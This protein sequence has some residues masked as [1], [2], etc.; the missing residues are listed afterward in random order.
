MPLILLP[1]SKKLLNLSN[2][3]TIEFE[4]ERDSD[5]VVR[6]VVKMVSGVRVFI[7][8]KGDILELASGINCS[9]TIKN[10]IRNQISLAGIMEKDKP[11]EVKWLER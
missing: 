6:V 9:G 4:T 7:H 10:Q 5:K 8:D 1:S 11:M 3:E 2:I